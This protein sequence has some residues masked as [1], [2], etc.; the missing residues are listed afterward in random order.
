M[1]KIKG[2]DFYNSG[3]YLY[4]EIFID[5]YAGGW[6]AFDGNHIYSNF[7]KE[8]IGKSLKKICKLIDKELDLNSLRFILGK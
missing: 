1:I 2:L 8:L 4:R 5:K 7:P 6:V 3:E